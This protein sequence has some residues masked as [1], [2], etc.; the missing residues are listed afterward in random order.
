MGPPSK[1]SSKPKKVPVLKSKPTKPKQTT[2]SFESSSSQSS[3]SQSSK[4]M[5]SLGALQPFKFAVPDVPSKRACPLPPSSSS[6]SSKP[7]TSK[8]RKIVEVIELSDSDEEDVRSDGEVEEVKPKGRKKEEK[9]RRSVS[10][11][12]T[13]S[14]EKGKG[15]ARD[16]SQSRGRGEQVEEEGLWTDLYPPR[17]SSELAVHK[18]KVKE[19]QDWLNEAFPPVNDST[20]GAPPSKLLKYRRIL[21]LSGPSGVGKTATIKA[22]ASEMGLEVL[23]WVEGAEEHGIGGSFGAE[24]LISR[25]TS[26][27]SRAS[28][29]SL[30]FSSKSASSSSHQPTTRK[31]L[32]LD[33]LPNISHSGTRQAF[34]AALLEFATFWTPSSSPLVVVVTDPGDGGKAGESWMDHRRDD[35]WDLRAVLGLELSEGPYTRVVNFNPIAP[36]LLTKSLTKLLSLTHTSSSRRPPKDAIDLIVQSSNGD[37]RSAI[38]ALQFLCRVEMSSGKGGGGGAAGKLKG[39]G[40]RGGKGGKSQ[41]GKELKALMEAVTRREQSLA[42]FHALGKVLYNKRWGDPDPKGEEDEDEAPESVET[43][44]LPDHLAHHQK[45]ISKVDVETLFLDAPVDTSLYNLYLHQNYPLFCGDI[46]ECFDSIEAL[47]GSDAMKTDEDLWQSSKI[48]IAYAFNLTVRGLLAGLPSPVERKGQKMY[49]PDWFDSAKKQ[50][51]NETN[52]DD[53]AS[54]CA[55]LGLGMGGGDSSVVPCLPPLALPPPLQ[56]TLP[57]PVDA[58]HPL[59]DGRAGGGR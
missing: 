51:A 58:K 29:P 59:P 42:L 45:R 39:K 7:N 30:S 16:Q 11:T 41:A 53:I 37:I 48:S 9:E 43:I 22:L 38:N 36:T 44:P 31:L 47:S 15:K 35:G 57:D 27:L 3:S 21:A 10:S 54:W 23:E 50:R 6:S 1:P 26:F 12:S 24:S 46:D 40:S 4:P 28:A 33:D 8:K 20:D 2:L 56:P 25:F 52:V 17:D 19:V 34:Q 5:K 14:K 18:K 55:K 32:L 13:S 49:K